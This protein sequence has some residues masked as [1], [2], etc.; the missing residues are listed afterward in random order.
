MKTNFIV[1]ESST[2]SIFRTKP[3]ATFIGESEDQNENI[4]DHHISLR[5]IDNL[6]KARLVPPN[7]FSFLLLHHSHILRDEDS[8]GFLARKKG[9]N[10]HS[11]LARL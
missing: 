6:K 8:F 1:R 4:L 5:S 3:N 11:H 10:P 7:S 2:F 9:T